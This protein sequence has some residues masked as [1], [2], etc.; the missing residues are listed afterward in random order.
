MTLP[1]FLRVAAEE[2][3]FR[4]LELREYSRCA[5]SRARLTPAFGAVTDVEREGFGQRGLEL[6]RAA[7][8]SCV[9]GGGGG[10]DDVVKGKVGGWVWVESR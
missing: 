1:G 2:I 9:H 10:G 8:A 3:R 5:K 4:Q 7:L 6:H